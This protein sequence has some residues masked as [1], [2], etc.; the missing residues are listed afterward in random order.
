M[1]SQVRKCGL[2]SALLAVALLQN[3]AIA[4]AS[5]DLSSPALRFSGFA[6][7]GAVKG[8]NDTLGFRREL[9]GEAVYDGDVNWSTDSL[10]GL[11]LDMRLTDKLD[12]A[13][14]LVVKDRLDDAVENQV[15]WAFLR[16]RFSPDWTLRVGRIGLDVYALSEYRSVGFSYLWVR[17]PVEFYAPVAFNSFDGLDL[18]WSN[19][20]GDGLFRAKLYGG[21]TGNDFDVADQITNLTLDPIFGL[22]LGWESDHWQLR[23][24]LS[25]TEVEE[26]QEYFP[27]LTQ[28]A[29]V[30]EQVQPLWPAA[31]NLRANLK[32][33]GAVVDYHS[34]GL[35]YTNAPWQV[36]AEVGYI[37]SQVDVYP[38][39]V[40]SYISV[41]RQFGAVTVYG[42]L[43]DTD[44][45]NERIEVNPPFIPFLPVESAQLALLGDALQTAFDSASMD[46]SSISLGMRWD[47]RYDTALKMQW[48]RSWVKQYGAG[49]WELKNVPDDDQVLDTFTINLNVIF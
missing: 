20:L 30:L 7:V 19:P 5:D 22:S 32:S 15:E 28:L 6:T 12:G 24:T 34:M 16:Y 42:M 11:Q 4:L 43:A 9:P 27:G 26:D 33:A 18:T 13:V 37:D 2:A 25:R 21:R 49:L 46:Q 36:Q 10:L 31:E 48:D 47:V 3:G 39:L 1:G 38:A 40:N 45:Q 35:A 23:V 29:A 14:Q 17:P 8:G 41:G 44:N